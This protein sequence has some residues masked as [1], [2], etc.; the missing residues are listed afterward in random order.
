MG[1][2]IGS[3]KLKNICCWLKYNITVK[4]VEND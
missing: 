4:D 2:K 3:F 1:Y